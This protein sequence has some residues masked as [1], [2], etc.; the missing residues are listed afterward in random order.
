MQEVDSVANGPI[1]WCIM[2]W[3]FWVET[4]MHLCSLKAKSFAQPKISDV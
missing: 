2:L 3:R 4:V 1:N